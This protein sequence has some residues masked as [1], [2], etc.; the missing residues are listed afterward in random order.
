MIVRHRHR[1]AN[2]ALPLLGDQPR[3]FAFTPIRPRALGRLRTHRWRRSRY[4]R[5]EHC[6]RQQ[7]LCTL[8]LHTRRRQ[9][10]GI[11]RACSV[12]NQPQRGWSRA[13]PRHAR[14]T[15]PWRAQRRAISPEVL[16]HGM[17]SRGKRVIPMGDPVMLLITSNRWP[18]AGLIRHPTCNGRRSHRGRQRTRSNGSDANEPCAPLR[19]VVRCHSVCRRVRFIVAYRYHNADTCNTY[20]SSR[21]VFL[22]C[23]LLVLH[24]GRGHHTDHRAWHPL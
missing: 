21:F 15:L 18:A 11:S 16:P 20:R 24:A 10:R 13:R 12:S 1:G 8:H 14:R 17:P 9:H 6:Q 4:C 7:H 19:Y 23:G 22:F 5:R 3:R 2:L